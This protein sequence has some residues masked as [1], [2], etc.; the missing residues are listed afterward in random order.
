MPTLSEEH[1]D[2][3][4]VVARERRNLLITDSDFRRFDVNAVQKIG[5]PSP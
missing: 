2:V 1:V 5:P 3:R 4:I